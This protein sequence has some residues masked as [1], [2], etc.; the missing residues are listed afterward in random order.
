MAEHVLKLCKMISGWPGAI[1]VLLGL[2]QS[3]RKMSWWAANH[4]QLST[5]V[6]MHL[7]FIGS[8]QTVPALAMH[9]LFS[10][11]YLCPSWWSEKCLPRPSESWPKNSKKRRC[12]SSQI[13]LLS[14]DKTGISSLRES[15]SLFPH[16]SLNGYYAL[17]VRTVD[18]FTSRTHACHLLQ[19]L[20]RKACSVEIF[21]DCTK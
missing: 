17:F 4:R 1:Y 13:F 2:F 7:R 6:S 14:L 19:S 12:Q 11:F 20:V 10:S 15:H 16:Q 21:I 18:V 3:L 8:K 9:D 5:H